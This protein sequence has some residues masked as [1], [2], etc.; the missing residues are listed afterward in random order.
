MTTTLRPTG[1][2][3]R[4]PGGQRARVY[5]VCVNSRP[6]GGVELAT[7]S[8]YG[9]AVGRIAG[10]RIDEA[11]RRRGRGTVAALAAEEVLRGWGCRQIEASV[12]A[13]AS[14]ALRLAAALG[15]TERSRSMAKTVPRTPAALPEG[16]THQP[17]AEADYAAWQTAAKARYAMSMTDR[18]MPEDDAR[19]KADADHAAVLPD[20]IAS[21]GAVLRVLCHEGAAVGTLWISVAEDLPD[22]V[23][24][25][26]FDVEVT[27]EHRGRGHGR[28]LMLVA[29]HECR[30][31]AADR[32]GLHVFTTNT[33]ALRL[34]ESLGYET[35]RFHLAK[36]LV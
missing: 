27:A 21:P 22:G 16:T 18:G 31:A 8:R 11:E 14:A 24:G 2:E 17:M 3:R 30:E 13:A 4:E 26:V 35:A 9:P 1:P 32:I 5:D 29:E 28:S 15:Y 25:Y 36:P 34:Y 7:D 20:G 10:L 23:G 12:P 19:A 33:P 6:V